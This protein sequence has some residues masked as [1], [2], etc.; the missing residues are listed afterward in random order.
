MLPLLTSTVMNIDCSVAVFHFCHWVW[1][2][3]VCRCTCVF[4]P[5][6]DSTNWQKLSSEVP[7]NKIY[8]WNLYSI[9]TPSNSTNISFGVLQHRNNSILFQLNIKNEGRIENSSV[10]L[11]YSAENQVHETF[12]EWKSI[13]NCPSTPSQKISK[14]YFGCLE[15]GWLCPL[16]EISCCWK[17]C[18]KPL[19][20]H[21]EKNCLAL[22][23]ALSFQD[24]FACRLFLSAL[25]PAKW[26]EVDQMEQQPWHF[27]PK[28][29]VLLLF[30]ERK[31]HHFHHWSIIASPS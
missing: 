25:I 24:H 29:S 7:P 14:W 21:K 26:L 6:T 13:L 2:V 16:L 23:M 18:L 10:Q 4:S 20:K 8:N 12:T 22:Q 9:S 5:I 28:N 1:L 3:C 27:A 15:S 11:A 31:V 17:K 30:T 19:H